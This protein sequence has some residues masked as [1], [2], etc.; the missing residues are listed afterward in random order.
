[1]TGYG[2][3]LRIAIEDICGVDQISAAN[4]PKINCRIEATNRPGL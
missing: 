3:A 4:L 2:R 1:M